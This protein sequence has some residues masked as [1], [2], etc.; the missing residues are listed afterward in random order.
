MEKGADISVDGLYRYARQIWE[1][2]KPLVMLIGLNPST[3]DVT[4]DDRNVATS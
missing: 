3:A 2:T 4:T 1:P